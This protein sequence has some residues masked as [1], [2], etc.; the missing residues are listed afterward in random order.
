MQ[1]KTFS[2]SNEQINAGDSLQVKYVNVVFNAKI[3]S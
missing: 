2:V 3:P 1:S